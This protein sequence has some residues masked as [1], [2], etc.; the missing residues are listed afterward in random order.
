M[1]LLQ[2]DNQFYCIMIHNGGIKHSQN[3]I[4]PHNLIMWA[5]TNH[6]YEDLKN[7][8]TDTLHI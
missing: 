2:K 4:F 7:R 3:A 8:L 6:I 1:V 5:E